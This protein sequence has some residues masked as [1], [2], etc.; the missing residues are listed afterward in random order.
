MI[1]LIV[2][3]FFLFLVWVLFASGLE[4][5]LKIIVSVLALAFCLVVLLFNG[6]MNRESNSL[7]ANEDINLCGVSAKH[8]YRTNF[9]VTICVENKHSSATL[10]RLTMQVV[11]SVCDKTTCIEKQRVTRDILMNL[12]PSAKQNLI[13]N[14]S[15][16]AIDSGA[17]NLDWSV[18][19]VATKGLR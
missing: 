6:Y 19:V 3:F 1:G 16:D 4:R 11:A 14:L 7:I 18:E 13:Q 15:F 17:T 9:D 8:S 2:L 10:S 5:R 12:G